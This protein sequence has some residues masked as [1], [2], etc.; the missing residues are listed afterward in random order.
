MTWQRVPL[1]PN[2]AQAP[3]SQL[4]PATV[5]GLKVPLLS[6]L[7]FQQFLPQESRVP[8]VNLEGEKTDIKSRDGTKLKQLKKY[9]GPW[10][11]ISEMCEV[12]GFSWT[13][14][15]VVFQ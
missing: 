12:A 7:S 10:D 11:Y 5:L 3:G 4:S 13:L 2:H 8:A 15:W 9:Q 6:Q 14:V 1:S